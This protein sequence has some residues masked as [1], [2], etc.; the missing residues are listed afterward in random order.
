ML[1]TNRVIMMVGFIMTLALICS[2]L[3]AC[4]IGGRSPQ[5]VYFIANDEFTKLVKDYN[6]WFD[7]QTPEVQEKWI[8]NIDPKILEINLMF[9]EWRKFLDAGSFTG[10]YLE[11]WNNM[12]FPLLG[13]LV[14]AGVIKAE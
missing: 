2:F 8:K 9:R 11:V 4:A 5:Q 10:N 6:N 12:K 1:R 14:Q 3:G 7:L 13:V